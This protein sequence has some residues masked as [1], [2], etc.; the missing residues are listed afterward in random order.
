MDDE[1][2]VFDMTIKR[3]PSPIIPDTRRPPTHKQKNNLNQ[4]SSCHFFD[5][6]SFQTPTKVFEFKK[7]V[8]MDQ[9]YKKWPTKKVNKFE[10][11]AY[12]EGTCISGTTTNFLFGSPKKSAN[13]QFAFQNIFESAHPD[14]SRA[15]AEK[16]KKLKMDKQ[17]AFDQS[18]F[19]QPNFNERTTYDQVFDPNF[20]RRS[21]PQTEESKSTFLKSSPS[22]YVTMDSHKKKVDN[23]SSS[24]HTKLPKNSLEA[25]EWALVADKEKKRRASLNNFMI[26][27]KDFTQAW[28][29][30]SPLTSEFL[31]NLGGD[32][33]IPEN[34]TRKVE[35]L[36]DFKI[37][38]SSVPNQN[39]KLK[40]S[41][42][43]KIPFIAKRKPKLLRPP[44]A[45][46]LAS[47]TD[48][49]LS[50]FQKANP[51]KLVR[52]L[53]DENLQDSISF[54][55]LNS[56]HLVQQNADRPLA[57]ATSTT[58]SLQMNQFMVSQESRSASQEHSGWACHFLREGLHEN[59]NLIETTKK[60]AF[61]DDYDDFHRKQASQYFNHSG[62]QIEKK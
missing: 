32:Q 8:E 6:N 3:N 50:S 37:P 57:S 59:W 30:S 61:S 62:A 60:K 38:S 28:D 33:L 11:L 47:P 14:S 4:F 53:D 10:R 19:D 46:G 52:F 34:S 12:E 1:S 35:P 5:D 56:G 49:W 40:P 23:L 27:K 15:L 48:T 18:F 16:S 26:T 42:D 17:M 54:T 44:V 7:P 25:C 20:S 39:Q 13:Q 43:F 2:D 29:L 24:G 22:R 41:F 55:S 36:F 31:Q 9:K 58:T 45:R 21:S 51:A